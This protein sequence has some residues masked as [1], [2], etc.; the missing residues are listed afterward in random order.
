MSLSS[1]FKTD[2]KLETIGVAV[3]YGTTR[4]TIARAGGANKAY[5]KALDKKTRPIRRAIMADALDNEQGNA[6]LMEVYSETVILDW[7][8]KI[9]EEWRH[10]IDPED[11]GLTKVEDLKAENLL[12]VNSDNVLRALKNLPNLWIDLQSQASGIALFRGEEQKIA[13]K[14]L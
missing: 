10:G 4:V 8:T 11:A 2:E 9:G 7:E 1:I 12:A 13:T 14:N 6:I 3:D 5:V